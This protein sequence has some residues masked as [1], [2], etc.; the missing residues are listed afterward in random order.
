MKAVCRDAMSRAGAVMTLLVVVWSSGCALAP[1]SHFSSGLPGKALLSRD[2]APSLPD[3]VRVRPLTTGLL[4]ARQEPESAPQA[5]ADKADYQYLVGPGDVLNI[6]VWDHPELTIPAGSMRTPAESGN[7]VHA[8][9]TIFYP[10]V[11]RTEVAGLDVTAIRDL[12]TQRISR[13]IENPQVDVTVAAFRSQRV[14]VTGA[15]KQPG[16]LP[17]TNIPL[18]LLD[19]VNAVGGLGEQADWRNVTLTRGGV[20]YPLSL[21]ALYEHGDTRQN[22][23][24]RDDDVVHVGSNSDNKVFVMGEVRQPQT[25]LMDRNGLSLAG[26]LAAAGGLN[27]LTASASG[28]FVMRA[29]RAEDEPRIDVYQLNARNAAALVLADQF[30]LRPRDIVYVTAAPIARWNRLILQLLPTVQTVYFGA[31]AED[32]LR[33]P[34]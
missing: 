6:T 2:D 32:R 11:G 33:E 24:L 34:D 13:Y 10:Y 26:A 23:L 3:I 29:D 7:W 17:V 31:L 4:S 15:V 1:G 21:R 25:V 20:E 22:V 9:G 18:R 8:D 14:Y 30:D 16:A 5:P 28:V 12:I 19:A 27:E